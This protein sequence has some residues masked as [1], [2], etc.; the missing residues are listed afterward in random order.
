[1]TTSLKKIAKNEHRYAIKYI[2]NFLKQ[3]GFKPYAYGVSDIDRIIM[4]YEYKNNKKCELKKSVLRIY[5]IREWQINRKQK[6]KSIDINSEIYN[7]KPI[8]IP[9][10]K[11][12]DIKKLQNEMISAMIEFDKN[13]NKLR[14]KEFLKT[15]YWLFVRN[16]KLKEQL[17]CK[18]GSDKYLQVHHKTYEN[19]YHEHEHL[20]DLEVLCRNCHKNIHRKKQN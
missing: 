4:Y 1:M 17:K 15:Q 9:N 13:V 6:I 10:K 20:E 14:Y 5:A 19:H 12:S 11:Q 7:G 16:L 18:C 8:K 2:G 3:H